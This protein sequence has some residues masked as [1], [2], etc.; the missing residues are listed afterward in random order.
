MDDTLLSQLSLTDKYDYATDVMSVLQDIVGHL[1]NVRCQHAHLLAKMNAEISRIEMQ[2]Q[3][4]DNEHQDWMR[5]VEEW[6]ESIRIHGENQAHE[7]LHDLIRVGRSKLTYLEQTQEYPRQL[8][9]RLLDERRTLHK[10]MA[11]ITKE[12]SI[13]NTHIANHK[14]LRKES[15]SV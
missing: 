15:K 8:L 6:Q 2:I 1:H 7:M 13:T 9:V 3:I 4:A 10:K 11:W 14:V 5:I 12:I